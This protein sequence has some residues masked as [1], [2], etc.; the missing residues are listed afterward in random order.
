[1]TEKK[2]DVDDVAEQV[3]EAVQDGGGCTET[4]EALSDLREQ[5]DTSRRKFLRTMSTGA[6][7]TGG[8]GSLS[9]TAL[10]AEDKS[11]QLVQE[12]TGAKK[13]KLRAD[14][15]RT[16]ELKTLR[17]HVI[18]NLDAKLRTNRVSVYE[19]Q[20]EGESIDAVKFPIEGMENS[21][22]A[23][24]AILTQEGAVK[25]ALGTTTIADDD[26]VTEVNK[27][28]VAEDGSIKTTNA[29]TAT[30]EDRKKAL[31]EIERSSQTTDSEDEVSISRTISSSDCGNCSF[32][33][34]RLCDYGCIVGGAIFCGIIGIINIYGGL[35]CAVLYG[36]YCYEVGY[37]CYY[38]G[39]PRADCD[40]Y[41]NLC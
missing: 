3:N 15:L 23:S 35:A 30:P 1:M 5:S 18:K 16:D 6:A 37:P 26:T 17:Q 11:E 4:W 36:I 24:I 20:V 27:F 40:R 10:A 33:L 41:L 22:D 25:N 39:S 14:A 19:I 12:V 2:T 9:G 38:Y 34:R 31:T 32:V 13:N 28:A 7:A 29:P 8:I 21:V